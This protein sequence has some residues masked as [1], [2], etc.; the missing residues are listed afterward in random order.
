MKKTL[1]FLPVLLAVFLLIACEKE[2]RNIANNPEGTTPTPTPTPTPPSI[3]APVNPV[4]INTAEGLRLLQQM[5]GQWLGV[6]RVNATDYDFFV[7]DYRAISPGQVHGNFDGGTMGNILASFFVTDFKNTRTI[8]ARNGGLLNGIYRSSYFVLD[9]VSH[10][11]AED[12]YRLVDAEGGKDLMSMGLRFVGDSLYFNA[13]TSGLGQRI[14]RPH[15]SFRA[16]N[17]NASLA[18]TAAMRF[19]YPQNIPAKDFSNGF[20]QEHL[21]LPE[22]A[23]AN[24]KTASFLAQDTTFQKSVFE[25]AEESLDPYPILEQPYLGYLQLNFERSTAINNSNLWVLLSDEPLTDSN[26]ILVSDMDVYNSILASPVIVAEQNQYLMTYLHPGEYHLTVI[27]DINGDDDISN[28]GD[29]VSPSRQITI[30]PE[31]EHEVT[32]DNINVQN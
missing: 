11:A 20:N 5:Q 13:Y 10:T 8:M 4:D 6:N 26:G 30:D 21:Y 25:L 3:P 19:N 23:L 16:I 17:A 15:M 12:Y 32:I 22:N 24:R 1:S 7:Y 29:L 31:G 28:G 9:S 2:V 18:Q 14:P 27:A